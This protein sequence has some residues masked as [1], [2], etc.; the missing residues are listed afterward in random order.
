M[1][2]QLSLELANRGRKGVVKRL[3]QSITV[4]R[5][6]TIESIKKTI[7]QKA[8]VRDPNRIGLF[9][10]KTKKS[11]KDKAALIGDQEAV[12][13]EGQ[14]LVQDLGTY[15]VPSENHHLTG[16]DYR[17][18]NRLDDNLC[19]RVYWA[20]PTARPVVPL[21]SCHLVADTGIPKQCSTSD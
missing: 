15:P 6:S 16:S 5:T 9:D 7:A 2:N 20:H 12:V 18:S 21:P 4:E 8:G 3:P 11:I 14:L 10:P 19:H 17:S 1:S 13:A